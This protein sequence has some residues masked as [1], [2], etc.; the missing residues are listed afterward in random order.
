MSGS[1]PPKIIIV[2]GPTASGKT[3]FGIDLAKAVRGEIVGADSLQIYRHLDVGTAKPTAS[4]QAEVRHHLVDIRDPDETFNAAIF[5]ELADEA[6]ADILGRNKVPIII[7]GTGLYLRILVRG[8]FEAPD[9]DEAL[10]VQLDQEAETYGIEHLYRRLELVDPELAGKIESHDRSRIMRGLEIF[11]QTGIPLSQ[12]QKA[13]DYS[14]NSYHT[15]KIGL[16]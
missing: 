14:A 2:G 3:R 7:G 15:L 16:K 12:H 9:A 4:E 13:H 11:E 5:K 8:L 10:R 6:I 1:A